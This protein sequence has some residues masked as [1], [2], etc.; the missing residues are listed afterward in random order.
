VVKQSK[1][2]E[3]ERKRQEAERK[4]QEEERKRLQ[5]EQLANMSKLISDTQLLLEEYSWCLEGEG[6]DEI[7]MILEQAQMVVEVKDEEMAADVQMMLDMYL[8]SLDGAVVACGEKPP[9][10]EEDA[11]SA[12]SPEGATEAAD[13]SDDT[14]DTG[15]GAEEATDTPKEGDA[16]E[17]D[18]EEGDAEEGDAEEGIETPEAD[19]ASASEEAD[20]EVPADTE[21]VE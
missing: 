2:A 15:E 6:I 18:A 13:G 8:P 21:G 20:L 4:R 5:R 10:W 7:S 17:G 3:D 14:A 19:N 1:A 11:E 9:E 12:E 16:E